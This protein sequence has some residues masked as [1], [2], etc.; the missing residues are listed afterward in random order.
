MW[1][2]KDGLAVSQ[3]PKAGLTTLGEWL[4]P[5]ISV[6]NDDPR[7]MD[8]DRRVLFIR[9][10][11]TRL[12]SSFS[13]I[14]AFALRGKQHESKA[15]VFDWERFVDF[16]FEHD[17]AHWVPQLEWTGGLHTEVCRLEDLST[18]WHRYYSSPVLWLNRSVHLPTSSYR[19]GDIVNKYSEDFDLWL[20]TVG[21]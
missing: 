5:C 1:Y 20:K 9:N 17:D 21:E 10:P 14:S 18:Y 8:C 3:T 11:I 15:P 6:K 2:I 16:T 19:L 13:F 12:V 4:S 7:L